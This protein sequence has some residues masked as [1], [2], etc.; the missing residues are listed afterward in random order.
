MAGTIKE[1][2]SSIVKCVFCGK[3]GSGQA[4]EQVLPQW[5]LDEF[6]LPRDAAVPTHFGDSGEVL[7]DTSHDSGGFTTGGA[8][9]HGCSNGWMSMLESKAR[10]TITKLARG[11]LDTPDLSDEQTITVARWAFKTALCLH[12]ASN[13]QETVPREHFAHLMSHQDSLPAGVHVVGKTHR[14][15]QGFSSAQSTSWLVWQQF[16]EATEAELA[17]VRRTAYKICFQ[18]FDLLLLVAYNPL[19]NARVL[20]WQGVHVPLYPLP[21]PVTWMEQQ[22]KL[23]REGFA[24]LAAYHHAFG[25]APQQIEVGPLV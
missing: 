14:L 13:D 15:D 2:R 6:G 23:P 19:P 12:L 4:Q 20:L 8:V 9:C 3:L 1:W 17:E 10:P 11:R 22:K 21:G 7:S 18:L 5:V 24:A 25:L 16:R